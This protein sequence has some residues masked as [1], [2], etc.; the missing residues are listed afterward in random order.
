MDQRAA[1]A[2]LLAQLADLDDGRRHQAAAVL[3]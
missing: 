1:G 2:E 3:V